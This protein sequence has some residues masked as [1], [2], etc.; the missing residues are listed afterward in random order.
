[1]SI[2]VGFA[3]DLRLCTRKS[4]PSQLLTG[5]GETRASEQVRAIFRSLLQKACENGFRERNKS[6]YDAI[7]A[8]MRQIV[9]EHVRANSPEDVRALFSL[10][11]VE[12]P[13][14]SRAKRTV[15]QQYAWLSPDAIRAACETTVNVARDSASPHQ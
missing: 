9:M 2:S 10:D 4:M 14:A 5:A 12:E 8:Q 11:A 1:M 13:F 6:E 15:E 3:Q 7:I